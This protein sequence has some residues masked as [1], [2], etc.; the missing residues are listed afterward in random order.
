MRIWSVELCRLFGI[1]PEVAASQDLAI[2]DFVHPDDA[3]AFTGMRD[4]VLTKGVQ[5][6]GEHRIVRADGS[7][8]YVRTIARQLNADR[9]VVLATV[10]DITEYRAL[11][12]QAEQ[13]QRLDSIGRLAGGVAHDFNNLLTVING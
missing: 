9:K 11:R 4:R 2:L 10:Q 5:T 7:V 12:E 6:G 1:D 13:S 8:R 3:P